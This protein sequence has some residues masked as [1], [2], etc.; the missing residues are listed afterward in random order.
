MGTAR[1]TVD[2]VLEQL[3]PLDVSAKAMFGEYCVVDGDTLEDS[4]AF[5][6]WVTATAALRP[7]RKTKAKPRR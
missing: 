4:P 1:E 2:H 5:R 7:A 6:E 3:E